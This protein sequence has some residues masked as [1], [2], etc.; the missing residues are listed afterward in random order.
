MLSY[1][2][3]APAF[4]SSQQQKNNTSVFFLFALY[5][6]SVTAYIKLIDSVLLHS[7]WF[8]HSMAKSSLNCFLKFKTLFRSPPPGR[9]KE[10]EQGWKLP[11][12]MNNTIKPRFTAV[13]LISSAHPCNSYHSFTP[14]QQTGFCHTGNWVILFVCITVFSWHHHILLAIQTYISKVVL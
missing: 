10:A 5:N 4:L 1:W 12:H 6:V 14:L 9:C 8:R 7:S 13:K 11:I 3:F 2:T